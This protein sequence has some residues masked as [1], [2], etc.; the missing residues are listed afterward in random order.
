MLEKKDITNI[1]QN[2]TD[3]KDLDISALEK[4]IDLYP[5]S[6][7]LHLIRAKSQMVRKSFFTEADAIYAVDRPY[8]F[9]QIE[10]ESLDHHVHGIWSPEAVQR[11]L[12]P[13][14]KTKK[15]IPS[16]RPIIETETSPVESLPPKKEE[17]LIQADR[18]LTSQEIPLLPFESPTNEI[19]STA[20]RTDLETIP[21]AVEELDLIESDSKPDDR[22][23][24][25]N[26]VSDF[27]LT[28]SIDTNSNVAI[29]N[30]EPDDL[31]LS[32]YTQWLQKLKKPFKVNGNLKVVD[33][34]AEIPNEEIP[35][36]T[37][38]IITQ[39]KIIDEPKNEKKKES[40]SSEFPEKELIK[41]N[42]S[43]LAKSSNV[44]RERIASETLAEILLSQGHRDLAIQMYEKLRLLNPEKNSFFAEKI[45]NLKENK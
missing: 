40:K 31:I 12:S 30:K 28:E 9:R 32:S 24:T 15:A 45:R 2:L 39:D 11:K 42:V 13:K 5:Y 14:P 33:P 18:E 7:N 35:S 19:S 27:T 43:E 10:T 16:S 44:M 25:E 3:V 38:K 26:I 4:T 22:T 41:G 29:T 23:E 17:E 20:L 6:Q 37:E 1:L 8:F 21:E 36:D 34:D